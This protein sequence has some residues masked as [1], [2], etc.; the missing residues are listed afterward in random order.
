[1]RKWLSVGKISVALVLLLTISGIGMGVA[2]AQSGSPAVGTVLS[3]G[4]CAATQIATVGNTSSVYWGTDLGD[5]VSETILYA[6][7]SF[8]V[9]TAIDIVGWT[10]FEI[11]V[12]GQILYVPSGT[13]AGFGTPVPS[14]EVTTSEI[15]PA[16]VPTEVPTVETATT[17]TGLAV[18]TGTFGTCKTF[19]WRPVVSS[20]VAYWAAD[21]NASTGIAINAGSSF[22]VCTDSNIVGW[23][24]FQ[25]TI[26]GTLLYAPAGTF[27]GG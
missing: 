23:T 4:G 16:V 22:A 2:N 11:T 6:G 13:F 25:I 10:A 1:M 24:Q 12:P 14:G 21:P 26:P 5:V 8:Y 27:A 19:E 17:G 15:A 9:C 20:T 3:N 7:S 18:G